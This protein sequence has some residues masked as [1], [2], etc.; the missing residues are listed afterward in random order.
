MIFTVVV[1]LEFLMR[2]RNEIHTKYLLNSVKGRCKPNTV[3]QLEQSIEVGKRE[4]IMKL[5]YAFLSTF[6]R[7]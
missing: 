7:Y 2:V 1:R 3:T 6:L 5:D 4:R